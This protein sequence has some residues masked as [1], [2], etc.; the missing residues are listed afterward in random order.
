MQVAFDNVEALQRV[1]T[2]GHELHL[3]ALDRD[4]VLQV[5]AKVRLGL[6]PVFERLAVLAHDDER[7]LQRH[8]DG[9]REVEELER[10]IVERLNEASHR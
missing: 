10:V 4:F 9:E 5:H 6:R 2:Q 7:P 1:R 3:Q 8:E